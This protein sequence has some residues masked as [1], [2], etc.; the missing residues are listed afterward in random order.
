VHIADVNIRRKIHITYRLLYLK[1]VVLARILDDPTFSVLNSVIFYHQVDIATRLQ[2]EKDF[3][4]QLFE[5]FDESRG[6]S[7]ARKKEAI[8][9]IQNL[10]AM[11]KNLPVQTRNE[12]FQNLVAH[13]VFT[14]IPFALRH[15]EASVR[16]AGTDVLVALI[17]QDP[18]MVR[19]HIVQALN[20][21]MPPLT[22]TLIDLLL[23]EVD[24]GVKSQMADAIKI[25]LDP[26]STNVMDMMARQANSELLAKRN[27]AGPGSNGPNQISPQTEQFIN[28]FY[29]GGSARR[30]FQPLKDLEHRPSMQNLTLHETS[31]YS[32]LVEVLCF[33]VRAHAYRSK[34]FILSENLHSRIAQL[35][36]CPQK[37]MKVA[38]LKWFRTCV[39]LA[40]EFHNRQ[41]IQNRLF[42][43]ILDI[44]YQTMPRDNLLN[45][46]C[47]ELFEHIKRE[48][49]KQ[50]IIHLVEQYR[51]RL[52][53]VTYVNTF[54]AIV[55]KYD[56][57]Q[58]GYPASQNGAEDSSFTTQEGTPHRMF[59]GRHAFAGLKEMDHDEEA[60]FNADEDA[61]DD[62]E[63][64]LPT[65][66]NRIPNGASPVRPLVNYPDDDEEPMEIL[67]SS[68][69][70]EAQ[71]AK[72]KRRSSSSGPSSA[73][74]DAD[75]MEAE[76]TS[77]TTSSEMHERGRNRTP[78]P[79]EGSPGQ[80]QQ[81]Q[82]QQQQEEEEKEEEH[83]HH[84]HSPPESIA[85]K[86]RREDDDDDELGKMMGG[87]KRRNSAASLS[88]QTGRLQVNVPQS[89]LSNHV[90]AVDSGEFQE[91]HSRQQQSQQQ[92]PDE[93]RT[94][95]A[96]VP[97]LRR[98]G[99]LKAKSESQGGG[100]AGK[101]SI[102]PINLGNVRRPAESQNG[103]H[104]TS[105][106]R[107]QNG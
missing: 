45:S 87:I 47:L 15:H 22:D 31:L 41:M 73:E 10:C 43:P 85:S 58:T 66:A 53:A 5:I 54:Q 98:K 100:S 65:A 11:S 92:Q 89:P 46:A 17:D 36:T 27:G 19:N 14:V 3:L 38:A 70:R 67:A 78:V 75:T 26:G 91:H 63:G 64:G 2:A 82:Q 68:P 81:Q 104:E 107:G 94:P 96:H 28:S 49:H 59:N 106:G 105:G 79:V 88:S 21:K 33:F 39:S 1:D 50:L 29:E 60:Y 62:E 76:S 74:T 83:L 86:R 90:A 23:M 12:L 69:D 48:S 102:K 32:H 51:E 80:Q 95:P 18:H 25:L 30:L 35:L 93:N 103:N 57:W 24:L 6:E 7:H 77:V 34:L 55:H 84:H 44:V 37:Y 42:E 97:M 40:D 71:L 16:V 61:E 20:D 72:G 4:R 8:Q 52:M 56:Q 13:G 9:F 101:L 99:S